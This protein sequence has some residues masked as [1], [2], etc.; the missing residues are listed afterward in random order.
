MKIMK[1]KIRELGYELEETEDENE[2]RELGEKM[3]STGKTVL[4]NIFAFRKI[5]P[6]FDKIF[7]FEGKVSIFLKF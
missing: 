4:E 5:T 7:V 1:A 6:I 2:L 3:V